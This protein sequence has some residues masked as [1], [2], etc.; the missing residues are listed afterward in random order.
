MQPGENSR[1]FYILMRPEDPADMGWEAKEL[2]TECTFCWAKDIPF[3]TVLF[4]L[5]Q[6]A[7]GMTESGPNLDNPSESGSEPEID[8]N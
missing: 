7:A 5:S 8:K 4:F 1:L 3:R 6:S 2:T